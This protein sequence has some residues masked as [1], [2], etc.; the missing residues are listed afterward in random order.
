MKRHVLFLRAINVGGNNLVKMAD[1]RRVMEK[2]GFTDV[3]TLLASG[4]V[5]FSA[6]GKPA[7]LEATLEALVHE[8]LG[9]RSLTF[10]RTAQELTAV[11]NAEPFP[12]KDLSAPGNMLYVSFLRER[13]SKTAQ[14]ELLALANDV[15]AFHLD[16]REAYWLRRKSQGD[17]DFSNGVLEKTL[18]LPATMR[19]M[20]TLRKLA[21]KLVS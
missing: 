12:K 5:L 9:V 10:V 15:D 3:E 17:S 19:N 2:A 21:A 18:G 14:K 4:N 6:K 11:T 16:G 20:T 1:L 7:D 8:K 13:P